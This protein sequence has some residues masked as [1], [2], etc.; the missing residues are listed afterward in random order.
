MQRREG[1]KPAH[2]RFGEVR[3]AFPGADY[4]LAVVQIDH[5]KLDIELVDDDTRKPIGRPWLTLA[6]DVYS[7]MVTGFYLSLDPPSAFS[8]GMCVAHSANRKEAD[9]ERLSVKGEWPIW[10]IMNLIH[11]DNGKEFR[12]KTIAK[13]CD[14]YG[15]RIEWRPVKTPHYGGHIERLMGT[16]AT[17]IHALPGTT[18]SNPKQRGEYDPAKQASMTY[19]ELERWLTQFIVGVYHQRV[20][21]GIG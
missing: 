7:R 17:E 19:H 11:A 4:P 15:I 13:A 20:H 5:T 1:R 21:R 18:F 10:G 9:L 16:V 12:S 8:V 3:G 2:D 6:I 14:E